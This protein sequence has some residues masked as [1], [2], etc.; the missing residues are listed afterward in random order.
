METVKQIDASKEHYDALIAS[1]MAWEFH[2]WLTGNYNEDKGR[3]D[4]EIMSKIKL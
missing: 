4:K 3:F 1:G 2:P